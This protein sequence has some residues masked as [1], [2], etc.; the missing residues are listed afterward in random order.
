VDLVRKVFAPLAA[1]ELP[2]P[3]EPGS[4]LRHREVPRPS[5]SRCDSG[6][7]PCTCDC[8]VRE[9]SSQRE[10]IPARGSRLHCQFKAAGDVSA[11]VAGQGKPAGF[12]V[13]GTETWICSAEREIS[14]SDGG[15]IA[16]VQRS[17]K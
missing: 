14:A 5:A 9:G 10:N 12:R 2:I 4:S 8:V 11:C 7:R 17:C 6:Q 15:A 1:E 13:N 3:Q 16:L